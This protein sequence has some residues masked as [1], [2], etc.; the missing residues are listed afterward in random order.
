VHHERR[1]G[2][3]REAPPLQRRDRVDVR[4]ERV[5][6]ARARPPEHGVE[7][8]GTGRMH[9][10]VEH[11]V[12]EHPAVRDDATV[13]FPKAGP[14]PRLAADVLKARP[15]EV[16]DVLRPL[17][18]AQRPRVLHETLHAPEIGDARVLARSGGATAQAAGHA[19]AR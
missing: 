18:A 7:Q 5:R 3:T 14:P 17:R 13:L 19:P 11:A 16:A 10:E 15:G 12:L 4:V 8:L 1:V 9:A 6:L 2:R